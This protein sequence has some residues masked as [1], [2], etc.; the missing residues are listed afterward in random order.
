MGVQRTIYRKAFTLIELLVVIGVIAVLAGGIGM[1][2]RSNNHN[3]GLQAAQSTIA[4][5]VRLARAQ[6]ALKQQNVGIFVNMKTT[7]LDC[8]LRQLV[9]A[10]DT[11][12]LQNGTSWTLLD[13][14]TMLPQGIYVVPKTLP[15]GAPS[16]L[17]LSTALSSSNVNLAVNSTTAEAYA[18]VYI[19]PLGTPSSG[20]GNIVLSTATLKT[21]TGAPVLTFD[22]ANNVRGITISSY[23]IATLI[24]ESAGF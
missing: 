11:S 22:N 8:Y 19:K 15:A 4:G 24:N 16:A 12:V 20:G 9:F 5:M 14:G 10:V 6:A 13:G 3:T 1:T 2:L 21:D 18:Y 23:G 7:N 17:K